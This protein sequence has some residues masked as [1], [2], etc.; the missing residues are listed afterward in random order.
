MGYKLFHMIGINVGLAY[1][2]TAA[3]TNNIMSGFT[4]DIHIMSDSTEDIHVFRA[5]ISLEVSSAIQQFY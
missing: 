3:F 2:L 5:R 1:L 4:E